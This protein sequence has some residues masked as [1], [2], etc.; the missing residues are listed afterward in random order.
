MTPERVT[1]KPEETNTT[2]APEIHYGIFR[3]KMEEEWWEAGEKLFGVYFNPR[4]FVQV[5]DD[6]VPY[7][8][9]YLAK[10]RTSWTGTYPLQKVPDSWEVWWKCIFR[11]GN[12]RVYQKQTRAFHQRW[13]F[14][15]ERILKQGHRSLGITEISMY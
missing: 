7:T 4:I 2:E 1:M 5:M 13:V 10:I 3:L 6:Q 12:V 15:C 14:L 8:N 9:I 11:S